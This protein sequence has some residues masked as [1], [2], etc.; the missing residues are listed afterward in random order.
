MTM[1]YKGGFK[2]QTDRVMYLDTG[3]FPLRPI[4]TKW[5]ALDMEGRLTVQDGYCWD[6][7][8]GPTIDT[9]TFM[10]PS[11]GHDP[12]YEFLRKGLLP[13]NCGYRKQADQLLRRLCLEDGMNRF[14]AWYVYREV[15]RWAAS[16]ANPKHR[17]KLRQAPGVSWRTEKR[18]RI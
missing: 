2:Y 16:A 5:L 3:I 6:G 17:R 12:I 10:G 4:K 14:R 7:P 11:L 8:S 13:P 1:Y 9:D 18:T 15:R